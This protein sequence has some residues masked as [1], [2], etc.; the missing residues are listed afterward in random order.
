MAETV[1]QAAPAKQRRRINPLRTKLWRAM[2][3]L[4]EFTIGDLLAVCEVSSRASVNTFCFELRR[5]GY[6]MQ[7]RSPRKHGESRYRLLRDSG[8]ES[9]V[10]VRTRHLFWDPNDGKEYAD[11][12]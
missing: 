1:Q 8:P 7:R 5:A 11:E 3:I 2:R 10:R 9:P 6:L 4:R 12:R